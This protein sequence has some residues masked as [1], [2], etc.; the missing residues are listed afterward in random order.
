MKKLLAALLL[1]GSCVG[2]GTSIS[3]VKKLPLEETQQEV[4]ESFRELADK[5][6]SPPVV[7]CLPKKKCIVHYKLRDAITSDSAQEA[8]DWIEAAEKAKADYFIL[9]LNTP[10]GSVY[11]G[12]ELSKR[13]EEAKIPV[14]VIVDGMAASMGAFITQAAPLRFMTL[15]STMMFHEPS[16]SGMLQGNPNDFESVT[17]M[18]KSLSR[19]LAL[20]CQHKLTISLEEY[21][22]KTDGGKQWWLSAD[23]ALQVNAVDGIVDNYQHFEE[24]IASLVPSKN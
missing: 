24:F 2:C 6:Y 8:M 20:F 23:E 22:A 14:A 19:A 11:D 13:I 7:Q 4:A 16:L 10:G 3:S 12:L 21:H 18:L 5:I 9:E 15:R 1:F 17:E